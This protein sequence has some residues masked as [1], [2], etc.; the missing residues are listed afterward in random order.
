[1]VAVSHP[2][3]DG[4]ELEWRD[5]DR[6]LYRR[7]SPRLDTGSSGPGERNPNQQHSIHGHPL[8][9]EGGWV[10]SEL[11]F[12]PEPPNPQAWE[13]LAIEGILAHELGHAMGFSHVP[14]DYPSW[15]MISPAVRPWPEDESRHAQLAYQ[16]GP[17]VLYPGLTPPSS[18]SNDATLSAL[19]LVGRDDDYG[20]TGF[21]AYPLD[22]IPVFDSAIQSYTA[23]APN[24]VTNVAL[25]ARVNEPKTQPSR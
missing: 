10:S 9:G 25:T 12:Q 23:T 11:V 3:L 1:M 6:G 19:E 20:V 16:V 24:N 8:H 14:G 15:I 2:P 17:N 7:A 13:P 4:C 18:L 5:S 22:F 21:F